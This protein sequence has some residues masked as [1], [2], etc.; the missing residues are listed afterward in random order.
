VKGLLRDAFA[1]RFRGEL[2]ASKVKPQS[3]ADGYMRALSDAGLFSQ[4]ELLAMVADVRAEGT[5]TEEP[6]ELAATG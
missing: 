5:P 2:H 6:R 1:A 3:Y 4:S